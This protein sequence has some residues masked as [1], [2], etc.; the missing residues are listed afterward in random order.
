MTSLI[1]QRFKRGW[2]TPLKNEN[3]VLAIGT[4]YPEGFQKKRCSATC[5]AGMVGFG[6]G[7]KFEDVKLVV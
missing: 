2:S 4:V 5:W 6:F 3:E 7:E 1:C